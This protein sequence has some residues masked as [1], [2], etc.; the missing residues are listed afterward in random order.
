VVENNIIIDTTDVAIYYDDR[1]RAS[2]IGAEG[3]WFSHNAELGE[4]IIANRNEIWTEAFP[5]YSQII[6][7]TSEY[8]GDLDDPLLSCNPANNVIKNNVYISR[9]L[10]N[11]Y[12]NEYTLANGQIEN[13]VTVQVSFDEIDAWAAGDYSILTDSRITEACPDFEAIPFAEIGRIK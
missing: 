6:P 4:D 8:T 2:A 12:I 9:S 11:E 5:I 7:Y 1:T 3:A 13:N 10:N